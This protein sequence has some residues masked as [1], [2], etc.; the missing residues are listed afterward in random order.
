MNKCVE[1][2]PKR[3]KYDMRD[4]NN[5]MIDSLFHKGNTLSEQD[6]IQV[7]KTIAKNHNATLSKIILT[8][9]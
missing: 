7:I 3:S 1:N 9:C 8:K 2:Y 4:V 6:A 5:I